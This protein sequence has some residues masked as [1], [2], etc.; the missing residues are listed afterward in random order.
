MLHGFR[1]LAARSPRD[2]GAMAAPAF[3]RIVYSALHP[4]PL[5]AGFRPLTR[6]RRGR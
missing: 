2:C 1:S 4:G 6:Q 5:P 3:V